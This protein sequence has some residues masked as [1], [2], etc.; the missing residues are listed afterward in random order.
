MDIG[1]MSTVLK[2]ALAVPS[3]V[4]YSAMYTHTLLL[5]AFCNIDDF[6]WGTK[7]SSDDGGSA[8]TSYRDFKIYYMAKWLF[9]NSLLAFFLVAMNEYFGGRGYVV[10]GIGGYAGI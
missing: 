7:G 3:Y 10:L 6:S 8:N 9:W 2:M 1:S 4:Y 5:Y